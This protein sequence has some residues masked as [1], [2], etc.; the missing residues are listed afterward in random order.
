MGENGSGIR[1]RGGDIQDFHT[2]RNECLQNGV[3]FEDSEFPAVDSSLQFSSRPDR[4]IQ[5]L[6]PMEIADDPQFFVEGYSRFD[7]QQGELGDCW[8]LAATATLT[9]DP[10]LFFRVVPD[11]QSF[12]EEY[13]GIF[14]FRYV[15]KRIVTN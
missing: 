15:C 13:A 4:P 12:N 14:H 1:S 8:L 7:V 10:K 3:L 9:Q 11:D 2:I 5:W 6:R